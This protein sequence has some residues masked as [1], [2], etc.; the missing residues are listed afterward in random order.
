M[1][2]TMTKRVTA[3]TLLL[4]AMLLLAACNTMEGM[5]EDMQSAG[6]GLEKEAQEAN[7]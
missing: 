2:E 5:G 6:S 1:H 7:D 4:G 3:T